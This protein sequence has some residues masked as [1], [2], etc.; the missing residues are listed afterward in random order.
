MMPAVYLTLKGTKKSFDLD[1]AIRFVAGQSGKRPDWQAL[2][3]YAPANGCFVELRD[4]PPDL[5]GNSKSE[6]EEV[7]EEY[8]TQHYAVTDDDI[9]RLKS[10]PTSWHF[11]DKRK[12]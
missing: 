7:T 11:V 1:A 5:R 6:S 9:R 8:L 3:V 4:S 10:D 2:V 12:R